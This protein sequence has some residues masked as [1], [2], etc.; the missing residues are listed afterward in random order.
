[1]GPQGATLALGKFDQTRLWFVAII[2]MCHTF[3]AMS[4]T[5]RRFIY[6]PKFII[7]VTN[8]LFAMKCGV[9]H[10]TMIQ[11]KRP[12][13]EHLFLELVRTFIP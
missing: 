13:M 11:T 10:S 1:M 12:N 8:D 6:V 4:L 3:L 2:V 5:F 7:V 9:P